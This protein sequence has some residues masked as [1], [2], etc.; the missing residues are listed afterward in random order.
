MYNPTHSESR[1]FYKMS[2]CGDLGET[3]SWKKRNKKKFLVVS[4][5]VNKK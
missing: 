2:I 1:N 3:A 4:L 5:Y